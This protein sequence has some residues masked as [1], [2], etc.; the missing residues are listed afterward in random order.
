MPLLEGALVVKGEPV[1]AVQ[2]PDH[3][4][5][6]ERARLGDSVVNE[7]G[8]VSGTAEEVGIFGYRSNTVII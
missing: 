1:L 6:G 7:H 8:S 3:L 2:A 4:L 5:H